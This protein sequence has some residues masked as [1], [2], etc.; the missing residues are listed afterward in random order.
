MKRIA[1]LLLPVLLACGL[2]AAERQLKVESFKEFRTP[3]GRT[4]RVENLG[5]PL[6]PKTAE[7]EFVT[8]AGGERIAWGVFRGT[9]EHYIVGY[10]EKTGLRTID[11][12]EF[13]G[14]HSYKPTIAPY[15][16][17]VYILAGNRGPHLL[18]HR[19]STGKTVELHHFTD[20][21]YWLG[22]A[23]DSKGRIFWG[24]Q[25]HPNHRD[26][27]IGVDPRTDKV[28]ITEK[29]CADPQQSYASSPA[30]DADDVMYIPIG[31]NYG[32]IWM[33]DLKTGAKKSILTPD[34]LAALARG[35]IN[36]PRLVLIEGKVYTQINSKVYRCT[37]E[38]LREVSGITPGTSWAPNAKFPSRQFRDDGT[39]AQRFTSEGL[40]L[41]HPD[42]SYEVVKIAG[43]PVIGHELYAVG[44]VY[45][46]RIFG[47]GIF[48]GDV[49]SFDPVTFKAVDYGRIGRAG[50][51]QYDLAAT[52]YGVLF[53]GY[54]GGYFDLLDPDKPLAPEVNPKP[55][56]D[57]RK[58]DQERPFRLT[59]ADKTNTVFYTGSM[60]TKN[61]LPGALS[62]IDLN[63]NV[64]TC[65]KN[66]IPDQ[67]IM[68]VVM[69]PGSPL[70]FGTS[71]ISGGTGSKA[72]E[73]TA[74]IFLFDPAS[75]KVI[76]RDNPLKRP[77]RNFQGSMNIADGRVLCIADDGSGL[78]P[79]I[80]DPKTRTSHVG[81]ALP[82]SCGWQAFA[83]KDPVDGRNYFTALGV[84]FEFDPK[85]NQTVELFRDPSLNT[86][87]NFKY[88]AEDKSFYYLDEARLMRWKFVK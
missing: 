52:P 65:W 58:Y 74:F 78:Y 69:L 19:I 86:T 85:T 68:D 71:N 77:V 13:F 28:I 72:T 62:R 87:R 55:I 75:G 37:P 46:G 9:I 45:K 36:L 81:D 18:K 70:L 48:G 73:K 29:I 5:L 6:T 16:D 8:T 84:F 50:V 40:I 11:V 76:W 82:R 51:Q 79:V 23:V 4:I 57:L 24:V 38:G 60:A 26:M 14:P 44:S 20:R 43:L 41:R 54:V 88:A 49:F 30:I 47:S 32:D 66:I 15:G 59:A 12:T 27:V 31:M 1:A 25:D 33:L 83:E 34:D 22:H 3:D 42:G 80:F 10:G 64:L 21:Y 56:T 17:C 61:R 39:T 2:S 63:G 7:I 67:S 35:K 53:C